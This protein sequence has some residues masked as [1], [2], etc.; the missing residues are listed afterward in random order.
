MVMEEHI[1]FGLL[2]H[3]Y[4]AWLSFADTACNQGTS[5][6]LKVEILTF[7][8]TIPTGPFSMFAQ[9]GAQAGLRSFSR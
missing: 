5:Q 2:L 3:N 9:K 6:P 7:Q 8:E 4:E 1:F